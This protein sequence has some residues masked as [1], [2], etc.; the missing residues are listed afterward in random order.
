[1]GNHTK[2]NFAKYLKANADNYCYQNGIRLTTEEATS[3][4]SEKN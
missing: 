2:K 4:L 1:M 3:N